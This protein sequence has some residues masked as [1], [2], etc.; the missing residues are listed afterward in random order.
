MKHGHVEAAKL[1]IFKGA[2]VNAKDSAGLTPL[3]LAGCNQ[4]TKC[5]EDMVQILVGNCADVN[6]R[7]NVT[8]E[9]PMLFK[10]LI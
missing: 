2:N 9:Q 6:V 4:D 8:G 1:L 7:N 10:F 3:L 5:F